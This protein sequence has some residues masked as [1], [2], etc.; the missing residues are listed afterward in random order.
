VNAGD[1]EPAL[2]RER[3][4][5]AFMLIAAAAIAI[6]LWS[7]Q[8]A[9]PVWTSSAARWA[10]ASSAVAIFLLAWTIGYG[11]RARRALHA[12][13]PAAQA[14]NASLAVVYA[15]QTG[16]AEQLAERTVASLRDAGVASHALSI[17]Q[18]DATLLARSGR[19]L[20]IA[21][22]TGEGDAPDSAARF[23]RR[24]MQTTLPLPGLQYGLLA[25]GDRE[26]LE[27]CG[28]GRRLDLW[29]RH[30][31]ATAL[32]DAVEVDDG[33]DGAL[34]HWLHHLR[35]LSGSSELPDWQAPEYRPWRL[36][37]RRCL[38][39]GSLGGA[40]FHLALVPSHPDDLSWTAGD[41]AEIGPRHGD[42]QIDAWLAAHRMD[43]DHVLQRG[44]QSMTLRQ[45]LARSHLPAV[46][47]GGL[48]TAHELVQTLQPLPHRE[49]SIA[50]LPSDGALH[51]LVRQLRRSD[52]SL[53]LGAAWLTESAPLD[54]PIDVRLRRNAGFHPPQGDRPLLLIGNGTGIAGLRALVKARAAFGHRRNWLLFGERQQAVDRFY[55]DEIEAW[56]RDG[57]LE[58]LDLVWSRDGVERSYVQHRLEQHAIEV[59]RWVEAGAA[60]YVC[61]SLEGMA[62]A[63][64]AT[65]RGII[66]DAAVDALAE[67][68]GYRRDVY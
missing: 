31:G 32:F 14:A 67:S 1:R 5:D 56:H 38:N 63:V 9:A 52:G 57:V 64:D 45:W 18:L 40:A 34:R 24:V 20:F 68:G 42:A 19:L 46:D 4:G 41:I 61:G 7:L 49:Y 3:I 44:S 48:L 25:L 22:T 10:A 12:T 55:T 17:A 47:A 53:G 23:V 43:G 27:F 28:F 58:R 21:S 11:R 66:G 30:Q 15:S 51:L 62:G 37:E 16:F 8:D 33:D 59:R 50:S 13:P 36:S 26:Y 39:P 35:Q 29:L 54:H 6:G 60:V 65:L 2:L